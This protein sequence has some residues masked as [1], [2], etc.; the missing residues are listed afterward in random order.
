MNTLHRPQRSRKAPGRP[1]RV[2]P[3]RRVSETRSFNRFVQA[4]PRAPG[5]IIPH[6]HPIDE[7]RHGAGE[8][9]GAVRI[10]EAVRGASGAPVQRT[11]ETL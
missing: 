1:D 8:A 9:A 5:Q 11:P 2:S 10:G 3:G 4:Q 7:P 6:L